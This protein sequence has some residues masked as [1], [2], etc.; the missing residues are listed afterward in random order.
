MKKPTTA[1]LTH[2]DANWILTVLIDAADAGAP[3]TVGL[4]TSFAI[5]SPVQLL[6]DSAEECVGKHYAFA[7]EIDEAT[8]RPKWITLARQV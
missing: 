1:F 8:G 3:L 7:V 4:E 6:F 2:F 5:H